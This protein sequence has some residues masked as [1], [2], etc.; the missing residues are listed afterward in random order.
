MDDPDLT[1]SGST[2][3]GHATWRQYP[4]FYFL[5]LG[6]LA[7]AYAV[8]AEPGAVRLGR[9]WVA[10]R[11]DELA[12]ACMG[13]NPARLKLAASPWGPGSRGWPAALYAVSQRT[14]AGPQA[15]DFNRSMIT[16]CCVILGGLGNRPGVLLGV[17]LLVGYDQI[18]TP[19][20]R[21]LSPAASGPEQFPES[22]RGK[23]YLKVSGWRLLIFGAALILMM[24][25]RPEGLLPRGAV[26]HELHPDDGR[27]RDAAQAP[28]GGELMPIVA[29]DRSRS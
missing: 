13:L 27:R 8:P 19:D 28:T 23:Q 18:L 2:R 10:L 16:I 17:F 3:L 29:V 5:C 6:V 12:A 14:T 21:Q 24:R 4:Y 15:Y 25:F 20:A 9:A 26:K 11:E 1:A 7:L 22:M